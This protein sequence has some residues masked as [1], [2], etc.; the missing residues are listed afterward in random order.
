MQVPLSVLSFGF[1]NN[2]KPL[3]V[4]TIHSE[5]EVPSFDQQEEISEA[6]FIRIRMSFIARYVYLFIHLFI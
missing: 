3:G 2:P 1:W 6:A 4:F 5:V